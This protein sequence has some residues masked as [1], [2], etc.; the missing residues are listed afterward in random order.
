MKKWLETKA[1]KFYYSIKITTEEYTNYS[2]SS[3]D[4]EDDLINEEEQKKHQ[5]PKARS[6]AVSAEAFGLH[7]KRSDYKPKKISKNAS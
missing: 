2:D 4:E 5:K 1:S 6:N 3:D 7:N